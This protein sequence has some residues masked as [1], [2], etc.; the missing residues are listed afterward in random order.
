MNEEFTPITSQEALDAVLKDRLNRQKE[1]H[2]REMSEM[3]DKY[4]D[5][6]A[7]KAQN[8]EYSQ[9]IMALNS[10]LEESKQKVA[11]YDSQIAERDAK[12]SAYEVSIMKSYIAATYGLAP[13]LAQRLSGN[14]EEELKE[15]AEKLSVIVGKSHRVAPLADVTTTNADDGVMAAFKKLNPNINL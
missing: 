7:L 13:E 8:D 10:A 1:K 14:T 4:K 12:I 15:D 3:S 6:D 9:Q 5:Y 11:G 2:V